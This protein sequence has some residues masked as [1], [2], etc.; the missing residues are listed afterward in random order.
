[1]FRVLIWGHAAITLALAAIA[2]ILI[3][4]SESLKNTL[5]GKLIVIFIIVMAVILFLMSFDTFR[6][7]LAKIFL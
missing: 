1:M 5:K 7:L 6:V 2:Y 3:Q 4:N